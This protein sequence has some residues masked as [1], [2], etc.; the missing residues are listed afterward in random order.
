[1]TLQ[2]LRVC[3]SLEEFQRSQNPLVTE[4]YALVTKRNIATRWRTTLET[5]CVLFFCDYCTQGRIGAF[6]RSLSTNLCSVD[7]RLMQPRYNTTQHNMLKNT[8]QKR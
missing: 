1:M 5:E 4:N 8:G 3:L 2:G 7:L 6:S